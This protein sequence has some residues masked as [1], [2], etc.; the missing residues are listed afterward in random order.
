MILFHILSV[1]FIWLFGFVSALPHPIQDAGM[2]SIRLCYHLFIINYLLSDNSTRCEFSSIPTGYL[3]I[4]KT[5]SVPGECMIVTC[6][7]D[8]TITG[9][10]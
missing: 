9:L 8:L 10:T 1:S 2:Y 5:I 6:Q 3:T 7:E 4:G